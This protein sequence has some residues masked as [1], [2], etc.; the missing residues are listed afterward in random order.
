MKIGTPAQEFNVAFD[1]AASTWVP[2]NTCPEGTTCFGRKAFKSNESSTHT[3][4]SHNGFSEF[5]SGNV[6]GDEIDDVQELGGV[7]IGKLRFINALSV[8]G[9]YNYTEE[10]FD[11]VFGLRL[12]TH[13]PL[14]HMARTR[15]IAKPWLGLSF[16]ADSNV[17]GEAL[18][19]GANEQYYQGQLSFV[20]AELNTFQFRISR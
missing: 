9:A 2:A 19:G 3:V 15:V 4:I 20:D 7:E 16:S 11:G 14:T 17:S 13:S 10:P 1:M 18:F 6:T 5:R 12:G 8:H